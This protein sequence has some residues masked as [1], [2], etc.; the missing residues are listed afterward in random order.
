MGV[1]KFNFPSF[2]DWKEK[3]FE[4]RGKLGDYYLDIRPV[5]WSVN[6]DKPK[7]VYSIAV[8]TRENPLNVYSPTIYRE[9]FHY[10]HDEEKNL[11]NW[12]EKQVEDFNAFWKNFILKTYTEN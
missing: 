2:E 9:T 12:Y 11:Q 7:T 3:G 5:S 4:Y 10:L 1:K 6:T 8:S